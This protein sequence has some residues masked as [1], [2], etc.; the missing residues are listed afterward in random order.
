MTVSA[1]AQRRR[2]VAMLLLTNVL[3]GLSFPIVK[4][5]SLL[6]AR[7][8]PEAG[9]WF[10]TF[11]SIAPRFVLATVVLAVVQ[12]RGFWRI[13]GAEWRQGG[14][15]TVFLAAGMLLQNDG[16]HFTAASTSAF[17]TQLYALIIPVA[18]A[19]WH[20][21]PPGVKV[22]ASCALVLAGVALLGRFDWRAFSFGRGETETLLCSVFF[23]GQIICLGWKRYGHNRPE[24]ITFVIFALLAVIFWPLAALA[25]PDTATLLAPWRSGPW[26][27]LTLILTLFC[28]IGA[29]WLMTIWQPRLSAT[30][31]GLIYCIEPICASLLAL[32][33]PAWFSVWAGLDYPNETITWTLLVGGGLITLAN[34]LMLFRPE[35]EPSTSG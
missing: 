19:V 16:L 30:E 29:F 13:T 4:S 11:Y 18:L 27:G 28:T 21:R 8:V 6:H 34:V 17:L 26:L 23:A 1:A 24:K 25:A 33:L 31:A 35:P 2:A 12:G 10:A 15:I 32:F 7:L 20:R 22:W 14:L 3:W 9:T 5:L